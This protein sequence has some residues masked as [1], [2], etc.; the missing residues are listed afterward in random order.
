MQLGEKRGKNTEKSK[1][2]KNHLRCGEKVSYT[3][4]Q[5]TKRRNMGQRSCLK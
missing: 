5:G 1:E 4:N 3:H 2:Y